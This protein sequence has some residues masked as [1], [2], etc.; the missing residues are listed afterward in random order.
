MTLALTISLTLVTIC[1]ISTVSLHLMIKKEDE[2]VTR[3][4]G[5]E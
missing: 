3:S 5:E 1:L 4:L 2:M